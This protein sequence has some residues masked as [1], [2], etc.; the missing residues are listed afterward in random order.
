MSDLIKFVINK[1]AKLKIEFSF[2]QGNLYKFFFF[3]FINYENLQVETQNSI[4]SVQTQYN[5]STLSTN[6]LS[7]CLN[8]DN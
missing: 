6:N 7:M 5:D 1:K 3:F 8:H 4:H 2:T